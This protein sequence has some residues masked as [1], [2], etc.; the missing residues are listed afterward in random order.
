MFGLAILLPWMFSSNT[1]PVALIVTGSVLFI[2]GAIYLTLVTIWHWKDRYRG[3]HS[4][5]WGGLIMLETTGWFRIAY[6]FRHV[7]ADARG[8]GRYGRSDTPPLAA[9]SGFQP[10]DSVPQ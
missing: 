8:K 2:P 4:D 3:R 1:P 7:M 6:L 10:P 5:L 9:S